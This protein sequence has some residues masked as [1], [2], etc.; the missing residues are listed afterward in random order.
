MPGPA[1]S[2]PPSPPP[3]PAAAPPPEALGLRGVAAAYV[4]LVDRL[5]APER[6]GLGALFQVRFI[7]G[8]AVLGL[9]VAAAS[10]TMEALAGHSVSIVMIGAFAA[11][12][13][14][15]LVACRA[16]APL[17][18]LTW[19]TIVALSVFLVLQSLVTSE[20]QPQQLAW[21][22]LIPQVS[23]VLVGPSP[24]ASDRPPSRAPVVI[25]TA[26]ALGM[27]VGIIVAHDRGVALGV[28]AHHATLAYQIA[29]FATLLLSITGM[30]WLYDLTLRAA[31]RELRAL[32]QLLSVCAWC[33]QIRDGEQGWITIE[34]YVARHETPQLSH[35]ICPTCTARYFPDEP[36]PPG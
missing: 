34:Q 11:T 22:V 14:G 23:L 26:L 3:A 12:M 32:R 31:G 20:L 4:R 30:M 1:P 35:G 16:G 25:A 33:K 2:P 9:L 13:I 8:G 5:V 27:G 15:V 7:A 24:T 19:A 36:R 29:D 18:V 6:R 10:L 17:P 28:E 21:L